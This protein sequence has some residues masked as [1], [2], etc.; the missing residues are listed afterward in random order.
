M[1]PNEFS[2]KHLMRKPDATRR[3]GSIHVRGANK[4]SAALTAR[5]EHPLT[6]RRDFSFPEDHGQ[7]CF[8]QSNN[9]YCLGQEPSIRATRKKFGTTHQ[10]FELFVYFTSTIDNNLINTWLLK[11]VCRGKTVAVSNFVAQVATLWVVLAFDLIWTI[12]AAF[13]FEADGDVNRLF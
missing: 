6:I 9:I 4:P 2:S 7:I 12:S 5:A 1:K 11:S 13:W 10:D 3:H 8:R